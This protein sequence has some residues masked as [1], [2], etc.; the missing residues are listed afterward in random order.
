MLKRMANHSFFCSQHEFESH[1]GHLL[2][3]LNLLE[4][5]ATECTTPEHSP[6]SCLTSA[7]VSRSVDHLIFGRVCR[8]RRPS[9]GFASD[10]QQVTGG[11]IDSS[12]ALDAKQGS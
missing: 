5:L 3:F 9:P 12:P 6:E 11:M 1:S 2:P 7:L 4:D 10:R 8:S